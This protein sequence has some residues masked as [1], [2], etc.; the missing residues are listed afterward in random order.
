[1][2]EDYKNKVSYLEIL[3]YRL[4]NLISYFLENSDDAKNLYE[5]YKA[6]K[7]DKDIKK[8]LESLREKDKKIERL[9]NIIRGLEKKLIDDM[10]FID[11]LY[12]DS[13]YLSV[14]EFK[15]QHPYTAGSY[16]HCVETIN[17]LQELKKEIEEQREKEDK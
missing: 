10:L 14:E 11:E 5:D 3:V 1:M 17:K 4:N 12:N 2:I 9:N 8:E 7:N 13:H 15:K 6:K 16:D